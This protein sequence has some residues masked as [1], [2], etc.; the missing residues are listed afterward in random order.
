M[1]YQAACFKTASKAIYFF[2]LANSCISCALI[3]QRRNVNEYDKIDPPEK[4]IVGSNVKWRIVSNF[5]PTTA[6]YRYP[7]RRPNDWKNGFEIPTNYDGLVD[8]ET[9]TQIK[10]LALQ[11]NI[12]RAS[13]FNR[14][15]ELAVGENS[16]PHYNRGMSRYGY[17][18]Y[19]VNRTVF[20]TAEEYLSYVPGS[21]NRRVAQH[22]YTKTD[23]FIVSLSVGEN[24][25]CEWTINGK[26][27]NGRCNDYFYSISGPSHV[28]VRTSDGAISN[29][30]IDPREVTVAAL[31]D[32]Y[33]SGEGMVQGQ[34]KDAQCHR[35]GFSWPFLLSA[36]MAV[37][38]PSSLYH[39]VS[40]ACSGAKI[41]HLLSVPYEDTPEKPNHIFMNGWDGAKASWGKIPFRPKQPQID[42]LKQ[43]MCG[44]KNDCIES[45]TMSPDYILLSIGGND[46]GFATIVKDIIIRN[47]A[48]SDSTL[49]S[50]YKL[51][52]ERGLEEIEL[53]LIHI[54]EPTRPY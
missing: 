25:V 13:K 32:S 24:G 54:S 18:I 26:I 16:S 45:Q 50:N 51:L 46:A 23:H 17:Q 7:F 21:Q 53:S 10:K 3:D 38:D 44:Y 49:K 2:L 5:T 11:S 39:V 15:R 35:S 19:S 27:T 36:K 31:G 41:E 30:Y 14:S 28:S 43:D 40:R 52:L 20:N 33:I 37:L 42:A 34:W 6:G 29:E 9:T 12:L 1:D 48:K 8:N 47:I 22:Q 4:N